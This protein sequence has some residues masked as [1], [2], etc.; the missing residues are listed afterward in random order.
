MF[1]DKRL[2]G[3]CLRANY[4]QYNLTSQYLDVI[5][6]DAASLSRLL[7]IPAENLLMQQETKNNSDVGLFDA[8]ITDPPYGVRERSCRV[9]AAPIE[10]EPSMQTEC[11]INE[12][13]DG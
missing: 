12:I 2:A 5:I 11:Y 3:E 6:A 13:T 9:A 4:N 8:V 7:R 10:K 1:Q